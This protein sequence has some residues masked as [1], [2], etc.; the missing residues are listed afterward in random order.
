MR[1]ISEGEYNSLVRHDEDALIE[2]AKVFGIGGSE[3]DLEG[4][5]DDPDEPSIEQL[6]KLNNTYVVSTKDV[7]FVPSITG[8][9]TPDTQLQYVTQ[10]AADILPDDVL[11]SVS[12]PGLAC[13]VQ[14]V[15][16]FGSFK[17]GI[18]EIVR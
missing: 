9:R 12:V 1:Y 15:V 16:P 18:A 7:V 10:L 8:A 5:R 4:N 17:I 3:W 14:T 6:G 11:R 13:T 2:L